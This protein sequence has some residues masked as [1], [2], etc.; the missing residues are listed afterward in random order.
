MRI[1]RFQVRLE[2]PRTLH[3]DG[4][5]HLRIQCGNFQYGVGAP[6]G[7]I[8]L[9]LQ[10]P[11]SHFADPDLLYPQLR[12]ECRVAQGAVSADIELKPSR[13][14]SLSA[15]HNAAWAEIPPR[16]FQRIAA[17]GEIKRAPCF[18]TAEY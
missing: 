7:C 3:R 17:G 16:S 14:R 8:H 15:Q 9:P 10:L 4:G 13:E 1:V 6:G 18:Q 2:G 5:R 12:A 11:Y